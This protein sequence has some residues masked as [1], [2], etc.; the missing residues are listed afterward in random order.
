M[1][2]KVE[3][4]PTHKST[5]LSNVAYGSYV[6]PEVGDLRG[7]VCLWTANSIL[8]PLSDTKDERSRVSRVQIDSFS[9]P[10][11]VLKSGEVFTVTIE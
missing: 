10:V 1:I 2:A 8:I 4:E 7:K 11:S 6:I 5:L 3:Y 9:F